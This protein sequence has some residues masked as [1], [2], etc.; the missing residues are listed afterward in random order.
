MKKSRQRVAAGF[1]NWPNSS[2]PS[3]VPEPAW[4]KRKGVSIAAAPRSRAAL[5]E[6]GSVQ[7]AVQE[8]VVGEGE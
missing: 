6:G 8:H 4:G 3:G 2:H 1:K 5:A 7:G